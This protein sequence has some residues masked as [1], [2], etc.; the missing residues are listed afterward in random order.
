MRRNI[1]VEK[2]IKEGLSET[3]LVKLT[4]KQLGQLAERM[5][6]EQSTPQTTGKGVTTIS[7]KNP[8]AGDMA[9]NLNAQGVNVSITEK[10]SKM[11]DDCGKP[12]N[13]CSCD[14]S[15]M[16][17]ELKG[18][19]KRI[20]KNH[21]GKIDADDFKILN[22]EKEKKGYVVP[23]PPIPNFNGHKKETPKET[24]EGNKFSGELAKA[25]SQHKDSFNVDGKKYNV[26]EGKKCE[27]CGK[28]MT[29]C[30][31]DDRHLEEGLFGGGHKKVDTIKHDGHEIDVFTKGNEK[32]YGHPRKEGTKGKNDSER[33]VY[34]D[35]EGLKK[36]T[37]LMNKGEK[38]VNFPK[39]KKI[40][41]PDYKST[42]VDTNESK[43][44]A[45][46]SK[47]KKSEVVK[48]AK[49]GGDIGKKGK[50]F[51]KIADKA[52]K[53]YGSKEAGEK[54]AA[55]AMWKNIKR[56]GIEV[57]EWVNNLA[58]NNLYHSFTSKNEI[59]ELIQTK[60]NES[61]TMTHEFGPGIKK[62]HNGIPEFMT[63][64][65]ITSSG[66]A[67][68]P[69]KPKP[70]VKPGTTPKPKTPYQPGPGPNHKPKALAEKKM[71]PA[72]APTKPRT[73]PTTKPGTKP[74]K[75][76]PYLPKPGPNH[77]PKALAEKKDK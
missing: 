70:T 35:L 43:P 28:S 46:L 22:K 61:T 3:T 17:E 45:G 32:V 75:D 5:L 11:C 4:D 38:N 29:N 48:K 18:N 44:S 58:E 2:L 27:H 6:G 57:K 14:Y 62:G 76:S 52:S 34:S 7:G 65:S 64:D 41:N 74:K 21:N 19:Q 72:T 20:D 63:Y 16:D 15:H 39:S 1:I 53:K 68:A 40:S 33:L 51:E 50:G 30:S 31:C 10:E 13:K 73:K 77:K 36:S 49:H 55:A 9:K 8:A 12:M 42:V 23:K 66:P 71:G 56:E 59:M 24:K 26:E 54:V 60:L 67:T 37:S 25:K 69:T 47:E